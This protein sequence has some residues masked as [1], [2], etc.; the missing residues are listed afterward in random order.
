MKFVTN[1]IIRLKRGEKD[2]TISVK[3]VDFSKEKHK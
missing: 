1:A 2:L 3:I